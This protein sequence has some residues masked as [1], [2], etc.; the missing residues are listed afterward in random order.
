M[1]LLL[2][3]HNTT[4]SVNIMWLQRNQCVISN[5][6]LDCTEWINYFNPNDLHTFVCLV[7]EFTS[8]DVKFDKWKLE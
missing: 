7:C 4:P 5:N 6:W 8:V 2:H 3:I 1:K